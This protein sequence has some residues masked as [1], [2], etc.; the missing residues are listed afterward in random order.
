LHVIDTILE[1]LK[2]GEWHRRKE[3]ADKTRLQEVNVELITSFLA[4][5]D[6]LEL[7]KK[8]KKVKLSLHM[9]RFL[10]KIEAIEQVEAVEKRR[11]SALI[12]S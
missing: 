10:K 5:Y 2:N 9:L 1:L 6:F 12:L 4:E 8:D 11:G 3:I 7:D